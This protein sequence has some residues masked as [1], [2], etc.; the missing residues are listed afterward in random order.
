M[1]TKNESDDKTK[2]TEKDLDRLSYSQDTAVNTQN[3][4][5]LPVGF[6][7]LDPSFTVAGFL[8]SKNIIASPTSVP[9]I[10]YFQSPF[11]W[12][13]RK[14]VT[15]LSGAFMASTLAS[16]S[17][18]A[19]A[20][21]SEPLRNKWNLGDTQFNAGITLFVTGFAIAPMVLAPVSEVH[22]RYWVFVG[23][24]IVFFLGSL[25]CAV[26]ESFAGMMVAR[27]ITGNGAAVFATLTGGVVSDLYRKE[28]RNTPMALYSLSIMI[29]T[30]L[31]PLVS[32]AIVDRL[33]WRWIFYLQLITIG[34][35]TTIIFFLF[36]ETRSNVLLRRKCIS[37]N[38]V[39]YKTRNGTMVSFCPS[40]EEN[41]HI[42]IGMVWRSLA[43]PLRLLVTESILFWFSLWVSFAWAILYMQFS[44]IG[45]VFRGVYGFDSTQ[46]GAVYAAIVVGSI[47]S[48]T[49]AVIQEPLTRWILPHKTLSATPEQ[50][51]LSP[52]IQSILLPIGL[53]WFFMSA[54][55]DVSWISPTLA[56]GSCTMGIY[57]IYLAV[58]NYLADTYH[59]YASSALAAQSLCRNLLG[60]IFPL[61]TARMINS[62]TLTGTGGL[63]G[64]LGLLLTA[65]PWLLYFYGRGIRARSPFAKEME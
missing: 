24:G 3:G 45:L 21:A 58:F 37:L 28:D 65:I 61:L 1:S 33:G 43:F 34:T 13:H 36:Q 35:A 49:M 4:I 46:V 60:G 31:G 55:T 14:K 42:D 29:G 15:I 48:I 50:R 20:M 59:S 10:P 23:S 64:G 16:Y 47:L 26:T 56:I 52:C 53:F 22:G 39:Q 12:S 7:I 17:S 11:S 9:K 8:L 57:S 54:R 40:V 25:G 41:L 51:L 27:L 5:Q 2:T 63:L 6:E 38:S 62:L 32:G 44:S 30:G 18:G 19:Y